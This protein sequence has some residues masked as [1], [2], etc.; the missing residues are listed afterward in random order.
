MGIYDGKPVALVPKLDLKRA[1]PFLVAAVVVV[2][3][4]LFVFALI[5]ALQPQPINTRFSDNPLDLGE[6]MHTV[7]TVRVYNVLDETVSNAVL[8]VKPEAEDAFYKAT[9]SVTIPT[10]APGESREIDFVIRP[11]RETVTSGTYK[12]R[13]GL[14]LNSEQFEAETILKIEAV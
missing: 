13:V 4:V 5:N 9:D 11:N 2:V 12:I 7:L 1:K 6:K 8:T 3:V 10:F 14:V